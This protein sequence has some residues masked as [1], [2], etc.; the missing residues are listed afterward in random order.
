MTCLPNDLPKLNLNY[1][2]WNLKASYTSFIIV[3]T[4][5]VAIIAY[6]QVI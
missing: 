1:H 5:N 2:Q 6:K 3:V 4:F